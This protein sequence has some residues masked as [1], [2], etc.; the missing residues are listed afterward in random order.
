MKSLLRMPSLANMER[1]EAEY[2]YTDMRVAY[3][4]FRSCHRHQMAQ[5]AFHAEVVPVV[6]EVHLCL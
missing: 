5:V 1:C 2:E 3:L 6:V 4:L